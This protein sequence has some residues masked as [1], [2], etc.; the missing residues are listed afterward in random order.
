MS[1]VYEVVNHLRLAWRLFWDEDVRWWHRILFF[2]PLIY[3]AIPFRYDVLVDLAPVVGLLDDWLFALLSSYVFVFLCP[4]RVVR[5]HR[6]AI[7]LSHPDPEVRE[8]ARRDTVLLKA[9]SPIHRL[10]MYR[11][12][13]EPLACALG[14]VLLVGLS[15]L[16]GL[17]IGVILVLALGVSYVLARQAR[18]RALRGAVQANPEDHPQVYACLSRCYE[19]L[20]YVPV[21][22]YVMDSPRLHAFTFGI[23]HPYTVVLASGLLEACSTDELAVVIG[24][25]MG[26]VLFEHTFLSSLMGGLLYRRGLTGLTATAALFWSTIF[27]RWRRLAERTADRI[28][29]LVS[30]PADAK[31]VPMRPMARPAL[32]VCVR[33]MVKLAVGRDAEIDAEV[34]RILDRVYADV[35]PVGS[36]RR[37]GPIPI[38]GASDLFERLDGLVRTYPHLVA[39]VRALVDFDVELLAL[40]VEKWLAADA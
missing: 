40:D 23:E 10:E 16:G 6:A 25:E 20:A 24:H 31:R 32:E 26:H 36:A 34:E 13:R 27:V 19:Q 15:A 14:A 37:S 5:T 11:H 9:L 2:V 12:P 30:E 21:N 17:L 18:A 8:G 22:V 33:T 28:S 29:L 39:R 7:A 38:G 4:R 3:L 35:Q 1:F